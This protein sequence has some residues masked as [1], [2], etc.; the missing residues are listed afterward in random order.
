MQQ[1]CPKPWAGNPKKLGGYKQSLQ[2]FIDEWK[3]AKQDI[4]DN[5]GD[6]PNV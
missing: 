1:T 5:F 2:P 6:Y 4:I 3:Q